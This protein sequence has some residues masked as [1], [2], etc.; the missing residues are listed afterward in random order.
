MEYMKDI[1]SFSIAHTS[2]P[3]D[4]QA[5]LRLLAF[6]RVEKASHLALR[7]PDQHQLGATELS[8]KIEI[9]EC[10]MQWQ[11]SWACTWDPT[12]LKHIFA[13]CVAASDGGGG[14][15]GGLRLVVGVQ[16]RTTQTSC[17][18][19]NSRALQQNA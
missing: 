15:G 7:Y 14:G 11:K 13:V 10:A 1:P 19:N 17:E 16:G 3:P 8:V 9:G 18:Q 5:T 2:S 4:S 6:N 12:H